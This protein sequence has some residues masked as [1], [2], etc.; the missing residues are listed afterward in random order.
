L[1]K[2]EVEYDEEILFKASGKI[3]SSIEFHINLIVR[4][5]K[6]FSPEFFQNATGN[7]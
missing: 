6:I 3:N 5:S 2:T 1:S 7:M 4:I